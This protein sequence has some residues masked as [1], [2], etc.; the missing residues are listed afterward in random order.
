MTPRRKYE[1]GRCEDCGYEKR[2][3]LVYFWASNMPYRVCVEC[4]KPYRGQILKPCTP[5]CSHHAR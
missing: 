2:T 4:I 5:E 1:M 3:T